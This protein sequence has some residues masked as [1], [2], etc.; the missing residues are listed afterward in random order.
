MRDC[1]S[2][3]L[4]LLKEVIREAIAGIGRRCCK[5]GRRQTIHLTKETTHPGGQDFLAATSNTI[6]IKT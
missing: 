5:K 3:S 2:E 4:K 6:G 1:N